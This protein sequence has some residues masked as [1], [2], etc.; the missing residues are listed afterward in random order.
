MFTWRGVRPP[1]PRFGISSGR[2][3]FKAQGGV[4]PQN[5]GKLETSGKG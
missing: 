5:T 3:Y 1:P 2:S 4:R